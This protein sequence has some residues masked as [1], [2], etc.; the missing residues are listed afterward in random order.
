MAFCFLDIPPSAFVIGQGLGIPANANG[1]KICFDTYPN[2]GSNNPAPYPKI[3]IRYGAGYNECLSQ[4]TLDNNGTLNFI[5]SS[6][7]NHRAIAWRV[8]S[9]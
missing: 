2:C 8:K 6:T 1:L 5:R 7:Y 9:P 3:M 4:P